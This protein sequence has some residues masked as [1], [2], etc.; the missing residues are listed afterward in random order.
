MNHEDLLRET[1]ESKAA[2]ASTGLTLDDVRHSAATQRT[3][4][5]VA[6]GLAAAAVVVV[7]V[8]TAV[9][10]RPD[11]NEP[12]PAPSPPAT[13]AP[14]TPAPR[15]LDAIPQG[16]AP[17]ITYLQDGTVHLPQGATVPLP[18]GKAEVTAFTGYHG[19]WLVAVGA[20]ADRVSW[21]D[22]GGRK[23]T[24]GP[25]HGTFAVSEDG[26]Q[27]AYPQ[28][29]AIHVG[30]TSGMS[31]SE[32][33][34]PAGADQAWPIGF[35]RGGDLVYQAGDARVAITGR[36]T[37]HGMASA[38][39][40]SAADDLVA[41]VDSDGQTVV[42]SGSGQVLLTAAQWSVSA[43]SVDGRYAAATDGA[44][45]AAGT[46][47]A[48]LDAQTGRVI[49]QHALPGNGVGIG[50]R[51]VMDLDG[52]LLV[53]ATDGT[54]MG[55]TVLRLDRDGILTRATDIFPLDGG[56]DSTCVTFATRP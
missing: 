9:L 20:G 46:S 41:G 30:I 52:S 25:G 34:I 40:V 13:T 44:S 15:S 33:T 31:D 32:Q 7:V 19:G 11:G 45:D 39:A 6:V 35:L 55:E 28:S 8:P 1:L 54:T 3:R 23:Q 18:A 22:G 43:F 36:G 38:A 10:L 51:A 47:V 53:A 2:G 49:A 29:G 21:Y 4:R 48:I 5:R 17:G 24:D 42:I 56:S 12:S 27:T 26:T 16:R 37:L 50:P 14:T